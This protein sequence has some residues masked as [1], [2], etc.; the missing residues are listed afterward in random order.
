[1]CPILILKMGEKLNGLLGQPLPQNS[2][3]N[4]KWYTYI[5]LAGLEVALNVSV[6]ECKDLGHYCRIYKHCILRLYSIYLT[7]FLLPQLGWL[8]WLDVIL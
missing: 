3:K 1:M 4:K 6:S 2:I 5:L 7:F 8:S